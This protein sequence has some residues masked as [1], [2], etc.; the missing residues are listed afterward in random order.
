MDSMT[1]EQKFL[2]DLNGFLVVPGVLPA[3]QVARMLADL[4]AHGVKDPDNDAFASRFGSFLEWSDDWRG[5]VDHDRLLPVLRE[6]CGEKFR[7][8]HA[9]GM[10]MRAGG[11]KGT[12]DLHH[13]AG[14]FD[15]GSYY[16]THGER[17]H[18]GLIVVG[19]ALTEVAPGAGGFCCIPGTHKS[20][21]R[22]PEGYWSAVGNP[23]VRHVPLRA[24][25]AVVFTESLTHGTQPWTCTTHERRAVLLKYAPGYYT[26]SGGPV[27]IEDPSRFSERQQ[28]VLSGP[29]GLMRR[30]QVVSGRP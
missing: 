25:D 6:L 26:F 1:Q 10:A 13:H 15:H 18:N 12:E 14:L 11:R 19:F 7:L 16:V 27:R 9:Y 2:F 22:P 5:L 23:L 28:R 4:D 8:D 30:P 20:L 29:G 17:M 24:G 3:D 21:F